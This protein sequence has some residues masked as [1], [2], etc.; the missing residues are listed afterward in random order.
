MIGVRGLRGNLC[1]FVFQWRRA[2]VAFVRY[3]ALVALPEFVLQRQARR[4]YVSYSLH[5][6]QA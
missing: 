2:I 5:L 1:E 6:L 3:P 4:A